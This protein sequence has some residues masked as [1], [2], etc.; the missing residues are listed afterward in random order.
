ML[1]YPHTIENGHGERLTFLRRVSTPEGEVLE[2]ENVVQPDSG[3]P[4]HVHYF[5][6]EALTV[7]QGRIGF[8]RQDEEPQYAEAGATVAFKAGEMHRFW[9]AGDRELRCTGYI[10]PP[11]SIEY[12]LKG[13]YEA[14]KKSG[15][16]R[17][18]MFE[19]AWLMRRYGVEFGMAD[20]P[21]FVQR[22]IFPVVVAIGGML[23]KYKKFA[24]APPPA[25]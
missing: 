22:F 20:I 15:S 18:D 21:P 2:V 6:E 7:V 25:H 16:M 23:G 3:P 8:Q 1:T 14:Q 9:N 19:A 10:K 4:M 12:F 5:Q 13:I 11:D 17:P 24:D